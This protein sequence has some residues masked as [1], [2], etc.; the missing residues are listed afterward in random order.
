M[1]VSDSASLLK[2]STRA[3]RCLLPTFPPNGSIYLPTYLPTHKRRVC[4]CACEYYARDGE[5]ARIELTGRRVE[6]QQAQ[7]KRAPPPLPVQGRERQ[8]G[9]ADPLHGG[10]RHHLDDVFVL[11]SHGVAARVGSALQI[12]VGQ[13][14]ESARNEA[15][16]AIAHAVSFP[17]LAT[18]RAP[19][20][21]RPQ[22]SHG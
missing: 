7:G 8:Q 19:A 4:C 18:E 9:D 10:C 5:P 16:W 1:R 11:R 12:Q 15:Q 14:L 6:Q 2:S 22:A 21:E 3:R 17:P 20:E 13:V